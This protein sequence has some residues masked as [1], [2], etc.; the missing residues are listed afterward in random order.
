[1]GLQAVRCLPVKD[2]VTPAEQ[3]IFELHVFLH[4]EENERAESFPLAST[5]RVATEF[6][7]IVGSLRV[8]LAN[9]LAFLGLAVL[10]AGETARYEQFKN[11][12]QR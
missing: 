9:L 1:L 11:W 2:A 6:A 8:L 12:L 5:Q 3:S 10:P 4:V 7:R